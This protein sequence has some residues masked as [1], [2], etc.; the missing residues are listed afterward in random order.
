MIDNDN[1]ALRFWILASALFVAL[2][3]IAGVSCDLLP[4]GSLG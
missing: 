3:D 2:A 4:W 1:K